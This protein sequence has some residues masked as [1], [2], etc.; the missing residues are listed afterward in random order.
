VRHFRR[1]KEAEAL[2]REAAQQVNRGVSYSFD[3]DGSLVLKGRFPAEAGALI[4][5][6]LQAAT[7]VLDDAASVDEDGAFLTDKDVPAGTCNFSE[8]SPR[9]K[10]ADALVLMAESFLTHGAESMTGGDRHQI[11]VHVAAETLQHGQPGCCEIEDAP[12]IASETARRLACD[13]SVVMLTEDDQGHP[14]NVGRKTRSIPPALRRA[15]NARD[16]G[17]RFPGC[18]NT[19]F[20]DAHHIQ[21]WADGGETRQSNLVSLC[22]FHH[23][24]VHEGGIQIECLDDGAIRFVQPD[25]KSFDSGV[26]GHTSDWTQLPASNDKHSL[27]INRKT[28]IT[29]WQGERMDYGLGV[30]VLLQKWRR[31]NAIVQSE[32]GVISNQP[33]SR[34]GIAGINSCASRCTQSAFF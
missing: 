21:H 29:R 25:G 16:K 19:R 12:S 9:M 10:R 23:R 24:L 28:A 8:G 4:L 6:A 2:S 22:R 32:Q 26:P 5:K 20:V 11:V 1:A 27:R 18:T 34:S 31:C 7:Q 15:L 14:L 17:C 30:E 33:I 13:A 3:D